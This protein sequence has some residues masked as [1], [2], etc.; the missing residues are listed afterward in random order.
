MYIVNHAPLNSWITTNDFSLFL[1]AKI[2]QLE[3]MSLLWL[4]S[5]SRQSSCRFY[6]LQRFPHIVFLTLFLIKREW[7]LIT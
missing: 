3:A 1:F 5:S 7:N 4:E 2:L 6:I